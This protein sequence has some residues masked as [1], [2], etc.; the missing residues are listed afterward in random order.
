M[1]VSRK[2]TENDDPSPP[3]EGM[4]EGKM[5]GIVQTKWH[6]EGKYRDHETGPHPGHQI[7]LEWMWY[8]S[9][10]ARMF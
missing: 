2:D 4:S 8:D 5:M 10:L 6:F 1:S 9:I 3:F 7:H